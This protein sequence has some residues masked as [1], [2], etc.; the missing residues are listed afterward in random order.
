MHARHQKLIRKAYP[1]GSVPEELRRFGESGMGSG[2][3]AGPLGGG[4]GMAMSGGS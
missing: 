4:P 3:I 1:D 2:P